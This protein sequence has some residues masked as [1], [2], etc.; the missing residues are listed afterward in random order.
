MNVDP[1]DQ[2]VRWDHLLLMQLDLVMPRVLALT[3]SQRL[4]VA[5]SCAQIIAM[6]GDTFMY[7]S[8]TP[9]RFTLYPPDADWDPDRDPVDAEPL[10]PGR[11]PYSQVLAIG[12]LC[13]FLATP[14]MAQ[15]GVYGFARMFPITTEAFRKWHAHR[16]QTSV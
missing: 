15:P 6:A 12:M 10:L 16:Q 9:R 3:E 5:R 8:S 2:M 4:A 1:M 7:P 13:V 14:E 11:Y